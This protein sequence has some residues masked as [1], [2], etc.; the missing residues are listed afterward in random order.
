MATRLRPQITKVALVDAGAN[1][2]ADFV[3]Y[4][5]AEPHNHKEAPVADDIQKNLDEVTAELEAAKATLS[6][7]DAMSNDDLAALK[8]F[9][10]A[11][12][13]EAEINKADLPEPVRKALEDAEALQVRVAKMEADARVESFTKRAATEFAKVGDHDEIGALL[14]N[15]PAEQVEAVEK[16]LRSANERIDMSVVLKTVGTDGDADATDKVAKRA[17]EIRKENPDLSVAEA[18]SRAMAE[19]PEAAREAFART[20]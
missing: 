4:K 14:A 20:K 11:K 10:I 16:V 12:S 19:N 6:A 1:P 9:Q 17:E 13:E 5:A 15:L 2:D 3:F 7:L 18:H 8:G